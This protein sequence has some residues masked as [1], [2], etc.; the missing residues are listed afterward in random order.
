MRLGLK[1]SVAF[2]LALL[3]VGG[4]GIQS[5]LGIQRVTET[6]QWVAHSHEVMENLEHVLSVLKDAETGQRGFVLTGEDRYL[7]P[8]N[9]AAGEIQK[10][11]D[12][13]AS[14]TADNPE[15][16]ADI[17]RLRKL[18]GD[19]LDELRETIKLRRESGLEAALPVIRSDRGKTIMDETRK[20]V[21]GMG[22]RER[23]LLE[24]RNEAASEVATQTTQ[25]IALGVL[26]SLVILAVAAVIVTRT[27]RLADPGPIPEVTGRKWP[28]IAIRYAFAVAM[29]ALATEARWLLERHVGPMPL[30]LTWYPAVLL[31]ASIAG[32]GPGILATLLSALAADYWF[33]APVGQFSILGTNDAVA[34]GIF[35]GTGIFVSA[36][37]ERLRRARYSEAVS[38][39][40]ERELD[41]LNM[42]N[43]MALDLDHRIVR[44]S[45]GNRRL[46]GFE[47]QEAQ[48]QLTHEFLQ[49]H[50]SQPLE[51]IHVE[52][53]EKGYW[54][55][56][57]TRRYKD[58]TQLSLSLLWALRRD[59]R[60][61]PSAILEVSTDITPQ[62]AAEES[63]R[64]QS[65]ELAQQNE[66]LTQQTEELARQ[67]EEMTQ[68]SEELSEQNEELQTQSEEIQAMN[69]EL[70]HREKTLQTLLDAA[71]LPIGE[72]EVMGQMCQSAMGMI[73]Q[74]A[75]GAV[76]CE[77]RGDELHILAHAGFEGA[78]VPASWPANGSFIEM[79]MQQ[80]RTASLEDT[81]LRPDLRILPIP[82]H[83]RFAALL[84]S[85]VRLKGK[86]IGAVSIFSNQ[87][88]PWT[89]E[90]F[91]L[92]EWLAA[93]CSNTLEAMR[94]AE[95]VRHAQEQNDFLANILEASSQA[96]G[97][98]YPDG[99]LGLINKAFEQLT[100][101]TGDE[102]RSIDW[103][104]TLT[105]PQWREIEQRKLE[106]LERTGLPVR[107][108]KEYIRKDGTRVPIELLVDMAKDGED[109]PL[110]YY[111]FITDIADRKRAQE[112]LAE[113]RDR[114]DLALSSARM[115]TF[116]W[117]IVKDIRTWSEGVHRLLGTKPETFTGKAEEFFKV[118]HPEDRDTVQT[119]LSKA[120]ETE[121]T[122][123]TEYRAVWPDGDVRHIAARGMVH[124]DD[125]GR[126]VRMT[127][128]CWDI[129]GPKRAQE[130]LREARA[131]LEVRVKERTAEL[132]QTLAALRESEIRYGTLFEKMDEG[133]CVV[134]MIYDAQGKP[135]DYRFVEVNPTFEK[136]TGLKNALGKT[137]RE[138]VPGHEEHWFEIYG[139]VAR[140]GES[141]RF[142]NFAEA[143]RRHYDVFAFPIGEAHNRRVGILFKDISEQKNAETAL[144]E[145]YE[146]LEL[147]VADRTAELTRSNKELE[148][149]AYIASHDLQEPLRQ[150]RAYVQLLRD[151]HADKFDGKAGQYF[152]FVQDGASRMSDLVR[153]LLDYSRVGARD[154]QRQPVPSQQAMEVALD[155]LQASI[156]ESRARITHDELP[157]VLAEPTQ[158][159][160]LF[161]NLIGNAV[162]FRRYGQE[163]QIHV[164]CR[165]N[166][167]EW[168]FQVKD[169]GIGID[170]EYHEKVFL[171]FQRLHGRDKFPGTGIGLAICKKIV[172]QHG[173]KIWIESNP[174][175]G[176][177]FCFTLPEE[178]T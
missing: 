23:Q 19:K 12:K 1:I 127:G 162:K 178:K 161:Q 8:Y 3:I 124:R 92:I 58:G 139:K 18:S 135:V 116:D 150:V 26:L 158:L 37:A 146:T 79:V 7:E 128:I 144:H 22:G 157:T 145:A 177:T 131:S 69:V 111:S 84:S 30:F 164:G 43:V 4:V 13:V 80:D 20:L 77:R 154:V 29:V 78:V 86:P 71:R 14:L 82:G 175:E 126:P 129:T 170:P 104:N 28:K 101:Y 11:L 148:Q 168:V 45:E 85:P 102:L 76:V 173:G 98:G 171:I 62:K 107:Y 169:N 133:F 54:Q 41:L 110:Y 5:Y 16:Q 44:W 40:Q 151:R 59:Q 105:P 152:Q 17:Q 91:R 155:N 132:E 100:G 32:G 118:I 2:T 156:A 89:A 10:D 140:T 67:S 167:G 120:L 35:T 70:V 130:A 60:G 52:L 73:G 75:F 57:V 56:E 165:R 122:Y 141:T 121:A 55:G 123:E 72:Q 64:Q 46:Y 74:P 134:E 25:A 50:F 68:Q 96:F 81:S 112:A 153:G 9:T 88:H 24:K 138:L 125:A 119:A 106:E 166:G 136:H 6:N 147:R 174:G 66:E 39:T 36:L 99:R 108:E 87:A 117:D 93:K 34:M 137:I 61:Q 97:M 47:A 172:E 15:Q 95:E 33:I 94:L 160:Q 109:K 142:Q 53:N 48:G 163:P 49:T 21:S 114:L 143:M 51:Q 113:S 65:E 63:L 115:A 27:M 83:S 38:V 159:A 42:G 149:F 176:A 31:V 90:Q 103:A